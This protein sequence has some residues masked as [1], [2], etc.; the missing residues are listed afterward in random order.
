VEHNRNNVK[1]YFVWNEK[2]LRD[3]FPVLVVPIARAMRE[4]AANF[5]S[6]QLRRESIRRAR[7]WLDFVR[8]SRKQTSAA[9]G[10]D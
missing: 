8:F 1:D 9:F 4:K 3:A 10:S 5:L 2:L 7:G 6:R